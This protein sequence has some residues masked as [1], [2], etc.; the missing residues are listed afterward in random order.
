MPS[1]LISTFYSIEPLILPVHT[2]SPKKIILLIG[3]ESAASEEKI[4]TNIKH[5]EMIYKGVAE[6]KKIKLKGESIYE[7]T[8][9]ITEIIDNEDSV[10]VSISGGTRLNAM[11]LLYAS[12]ARKDRVEK[13]VCSDIIKGTLVEL[14]RL[15]FGITSAK[16]ELLQALANNEGTAV[17]KIAKQMNKT[18]GLLYQQ[19]KELKENGFVDESFKITEAGRLA[20]L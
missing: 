17:A 20:L 3:T 11:S 9:E 7:T 15:T 13:I 2:F 12:Y 6:I 10:I 16:L 1:T 4:N 18:R 14:P 19:L 5:I 8:K